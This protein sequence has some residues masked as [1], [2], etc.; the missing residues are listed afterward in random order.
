MGFLN[1]L[2]KLLDVAN[3]SSDKRKKFVEIFYQ[4]YYSRLVDAVGGLDPTYGQKLMYAI[5]HAKDNPEALG[6][7]WKELNGKEMFKA[8][9]DEVTDEVVGYLLNDVI[10]SASDAEK[11][12][13][14][15]SIGAS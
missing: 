2:N 13:I 14:L 4:Y 6:E 10:K 7:L 11:A 12:Q 15:Q 8:K 5:D 9:I 1:F 3:F